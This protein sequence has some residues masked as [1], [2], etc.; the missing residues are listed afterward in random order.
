MY[1]PRPE[2]YQRAPFGP[3]PPQAGAS[4]AQP[5]GAPGQ[6]NQPTSN[7]NAPFGQVYSTPTAPFAQA[8]LLSTAQPG[9]GVAHPPKRPGSGLRTGAI[10]ALIALL[11]AVFATG[12]FAGWQWERFISDQQFVPIRQLDRH[13]ATVDQ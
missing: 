7:M 12:L 9:M 13:R 8:N 2:Q 1:P 10:I 11:A 5:F 4:A 6:F 3:P